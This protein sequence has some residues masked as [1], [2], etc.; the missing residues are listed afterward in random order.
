MNASIRPLMLALP[1]LALVPAP[2]ALAQQPAATA[3]VAAAQAPAASAGDRIERITHEDS[4]SRIEELRVGGQTQSIEVQ[5]KNGAPAYQITT[6]QGLAPARGD[7][8]GQRTG[9]AGRSSW[10]IL[11]F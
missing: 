3:P 5:P 8:A 6:E 4:L 11:S 1:L 9:N 2:F 7:V 10:R